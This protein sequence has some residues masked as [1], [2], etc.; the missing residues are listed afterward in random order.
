VVFRIAHNVFVVSAET[1]I[2]G[3]E[4]QNEKGAGWRLLNLLFGDA[5]ERWGV[6]PANR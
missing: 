6:R 5:S 4:Q 3:S 2:K 1:G